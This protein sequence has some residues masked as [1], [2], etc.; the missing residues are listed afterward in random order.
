[1][2]GPAVVGESRARRVGH[3]QVEHILDPIR[4]PQHLKQRHLGRG[5]DA[6]KALLH[7]QEVV[8]RVR[9]VRIEIGVGHDETVPDDEQAVSPHLLS[10]DE[11]HGLG[12]LV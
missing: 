7:H 1:M 9:H 10:E 11:V 6:L 5:M 2:N 3:R 4:A 8:A 12:Q